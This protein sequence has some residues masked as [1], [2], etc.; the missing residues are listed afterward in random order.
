MQV[1]NITQ[2]YHP[3]A[4][5]IHWAVALSIILVFVLGLTVDSFPKSWTDAVINTHA[6]VGL[7]VLGLTFVRL[8][9]RL[10]HRPPDYPR[11]FSPLVRRM[12]HVVQSALYVLMLA[13]PLIGIPTL[14]YRGRGLNLG[15][16]EITS[17]IARAP[18]IFH[19]LTD[20]HGYAAYAL[21]ALAIGHMLAAFYHQF[22]L[23]DD[24]LSRM[25]TQRR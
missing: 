22:I 23:K 1:I 18:E 5:L 9:W 7:A 16:I 24:L 2:R 17:P 19:P 25:G 14:L 15:F 21:V 10:S 8:W 11:D 12:S 6:L 20:V 4:I 13:V 3:I